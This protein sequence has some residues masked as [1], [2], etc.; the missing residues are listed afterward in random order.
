MHAASTM[1]VPVLLEL[2]RQAVAQG[3]SLDVPVPVH[4]TFRSIADGSTFTL[5]PDD[6]SDRDI[7]EHVGAELPLRELALRMIAQSSNLAT[8]III[9]RVTADSV[10][11]LLRRIDAGGMR[12]LRGVQD[13][14]AFERGLSN[15]TTAE[16]YARVL[17]SLAHCAVLPREPCAHAHATLEAQ[18]FRDMIPAGLPPHVRVANKTGWITGI[19]HDGAL[20]YPSDGLPYVLVVLTRGLP[21]TA[22]AQQLASDIARLSWAALGD[23]GTLRRGRTS[24]ALDSLLALHARVRVGGI[25]TNTLGPDQFRASLLALLDG[26][27]MIGREEVGRSLEGRPL[28][29]FRFGTGPTRVLLWSQMHGDETTATRALAD[30]LHH[31]ATARPDDARV[32]RWHDELSVLVLPMLNPDGAER[33]ARRNIA[34]IDVNRDAR[35]LATPEGRALKAVHDRFRPH[36]GFNLHDQNPRWR[37]GTTSRRAAISLLAPPPDHART[38]TPQVARAERLATLM[39]RGVEPLVGGH[40]TRYDESFNPRAFGD[41]MQSWGT[42]TILVESGGWDGE[43]TK[44]LLRRVNF[45][46]LV[47]AL[48]ALATAAHERVD[49][50]WYRAL[51][52]NGR[53]LNDVLIAGGRVV[54]A[55]AAPVRADLLIDEDAPG[56]GWRLVEAGDLLDPVARDTIDATLAF[57]HFAAPLGPGPLPGFTI[58]TSED[59]ASTVLWTYGERMERARAQR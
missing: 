54:V 31:I 3:A 37:V 36:Y 44:H 42:A 21:D 33:H 56:T 7:Y 57:L 13:I 48:D 38:R 58:R 25:G 39:G 6:D 11:E 50:A 12:V 45:V 34:G 16:G 8:N 30:L 47:H 28:T 55:G 49:P 14:P 20:V 1:K 41:L 17:A 2:Y 4:A 26:A 19:R 5:G 59:S 53:A 40:I 32:R 35:E 15:T 27:T 43:P 23:G 24:V 46:M 29:L 52:P 22:A 9:E 51:P 10:N 18:R